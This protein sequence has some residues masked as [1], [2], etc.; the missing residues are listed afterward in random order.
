[1]KK[2]KATAQE[3]KI[4]REALIANGC[5]EKYIEKIVSD[6]PYVFLRA[7]G[8]LQFTSSPKK[9]KAKGFQP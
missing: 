3:I 1:M 2:R 7:D 8:G 6:R 4:F 5:P 9:K